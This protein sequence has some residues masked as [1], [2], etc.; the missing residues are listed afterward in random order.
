MRLTRH[1]YH[2]ASVHP[3]QRRRK[4]D[5]EDVQ[6]PSILDLVLGDEP[7]L[8]LRRSQPQS[9]PQHRRLFD[10][11]EFRPSTPN[12]KGVPVRLSS[13]D[14][15]PAFNRGSA[16]APRQQAETTLA[17][18][19]GTS[20][21]RPKSPTELSTERRRKTEELLNWFKDGFEDSDKDKRTA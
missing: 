16:V 21:T 17:S 3:E 19:E 2:W 7:K 14:T 9:K 10:K 18:L 4:S 5:T 15:G 12:A 1:N 8:R 20:G 6:K 13:A 11:D